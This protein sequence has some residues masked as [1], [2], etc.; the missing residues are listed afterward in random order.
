MSRKIK[1]KILAWLLLLTSSLMF[2]SIVI[3]L[4]ILSRRG[5][6][7][8]LLISAFIAAAPLYFLVRLDIW[9]LR[10]LLK[11]EG[12][13]P[14]KS[15][16]NFINEL[17]VREIVVISQLI[18]LLILYLAVARLF[19]QQYL[20]KKIMLVLAIIIYPLYLLVR[21]AVNLGLI[22]KELRNKKR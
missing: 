17:T 13:T 9:V 3:Y 20:L 8:S 4:V 14:K 19:P 22:F 15:S 10:T 16:I 21:V 18:G 1:E 11:A 7:A 5:S 2:W 12:R 6:G